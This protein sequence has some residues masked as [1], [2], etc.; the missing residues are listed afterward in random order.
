MEYWK[1]HRTENISDMALT[2]DGKII[3]SICRGNTLLLF[4]RESRCERVIEE[5]DRITSFS[6]SKDNKFLLVNI[7][8]QEIHLWRIT[9]DPK[10][11]SKFKGHKRTR[12]LVRSCFG[13]FEQAFIASGSEDSQVSL[14]HLSESQNS[15][16]HVL[17]LIL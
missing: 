3:I 7:V 9:G 6:L 13:G 14:F 2:S 11:V 12:F 5:E 1:G 17:L 4:N 8:N 16:F 15:S 10:I